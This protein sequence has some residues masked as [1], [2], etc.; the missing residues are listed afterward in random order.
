MDIETVR[1]ELHEHARQSRAESIEMYEEFARHHRDA[2]ETELAAYWQ[3]AADEER[4][5]PLPNAA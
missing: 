1:R 4:L 2:G 3:R 5:R